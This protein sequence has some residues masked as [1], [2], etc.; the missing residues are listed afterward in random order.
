MLTLV[1]HWRLTSEHLNFGVCISERTSAS[2][3]CTNT[4]QLPLCFCLVLY[5][6]TRP[7]FI[8]F[9]RKKSHLARRVLV[10]HNYTAFFY[11]QSQSRKARP[12]FLLHRSFLRFLNLRSDL[13]NLR[14]VYHKLFSVLEQLINTNSTSIVLF[15]SYH[16]QF[17]NQVS[18]YIS[19]MYA[20]CTC[21]ESWRCSQ[22]CTQVGSQLATY[23]YILF[24]IEKLTFHIYLLWH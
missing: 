3:E 20:C 19:F 8:F 10:A 5:V 13:T 12:L 6:I 4:S 18:D 9:T 2:F 14:T 1:F 23:V 22:V 17:T 24:P 21:I 15:K 7:L 16:L 11:R